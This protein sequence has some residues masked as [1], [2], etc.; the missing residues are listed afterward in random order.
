MCDMTSQAFSY[1]SRAMK[2]KWN[3]GFAIV[4]I[5]EN[6]RYYVTQIL[7]FEDTF[8]YNGKRYA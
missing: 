6:G 1:A 7:A 2:A 5:D 3:N 8:Y 4:H